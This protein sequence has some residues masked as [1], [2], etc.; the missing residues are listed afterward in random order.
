MR[1]IL[2]EKKTRSKFLNELLKNSLDDLV[3]LYKLSLWNSEYDSNESWPIVTIDF[4]DRNYIENKIVRGF[5]VY[6]SR[7]QWNMKSGV[8]KGYSFTRKEDNVCL[9]WF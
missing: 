6:R 4:K 7:V 1:L 2:N 5:F 8:V 9:T 3:E